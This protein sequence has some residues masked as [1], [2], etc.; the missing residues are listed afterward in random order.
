MGRTWPR[1]PKRGSRPITRPRSSNAMCSKRA[2]RLPQRVSV[3]LS[4]M[5]D[6]QVTIEAPRREPP[7]YGGLTGVI[8]TRKRANLA[9]AAIKSVLDQGLSQVTI[10]VADNSTDRARARALQAPL[11]GLDPRLRGLHPPPP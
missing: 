11:G 5:I 3:R 6:P 1:P 2:R 7:A 8:P 9:Q 10:L 4:V